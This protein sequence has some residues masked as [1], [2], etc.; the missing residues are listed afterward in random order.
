MGQTGYQAVVLCESLTVRKE[1]STGSKA[2]RTL[3]F[4][5]TFTT[6]YTGE[7]WTDCFLSGSRA[8]WVNAEYVAVN[9]AWY[10]CEG[11]T[12]V[13]AWND[14]LSPKVAL[15]DAGTR[16][17]ILKQEGDWVL[18]SLR[19]AAGWIQKTAADKVSADTAAAI[20]GIGPLLMANLKTPKGLYSLTSP[21]GL[22]WLENAFSQAQPITSAGCPFDA[23]LLLFT[24]EGGTVRLQIATDS[25]NNFRT[26]DG[27]SFRYGSATVSGSLLSQRFWDLFGLT[28]ESLY[29]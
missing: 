18:V 15:L 27:A 10:R 5:D 6:Q 20:S 21:E 9:P 24:Q 2:V 22:S 4:G 11:A 28:A 17:P 7:G 1:A 8:G 14:T 16:L 25:C 23:E 29:Q 19:G 13:Y 26:S 3:K 12:S